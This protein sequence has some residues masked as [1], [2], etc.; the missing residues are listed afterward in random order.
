MAIAREK[1]GSASLKQAALDE[2]FIQSLQVCTNCGAT[3]HLKQGRKSCPHCLGLLVVKITID[4]K[5]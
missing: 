2:K 5:A 1:I 3:F 4:K